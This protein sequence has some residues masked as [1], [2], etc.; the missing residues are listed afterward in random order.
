MSCIG[1][2]TFQRNTGKDRLGIECRVLY[3]LE[4]Y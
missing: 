2:E 3:W 4:D 1:S